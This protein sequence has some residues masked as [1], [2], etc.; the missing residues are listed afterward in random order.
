MT[1]LARV[2][3]ERL[4]KKELKLQKAEAFMVKYNE[5]ILKQQDKARIYAEKSVIRRAFSSAFG[6]FNS[7]KITIESTYEGA[8][9]PKGSAWEIPF[10]EGYVCIRGS[11]IR[12]RAWKNAPKDGVVFLPATSEDEIDVTTA[13]LLLNGES[14]IDP[15]E[16]KNYDSNRYHVD[17]LT[18]SIIV[19]K[20]GK[21]I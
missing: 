19:S 3:Q 21:R 4:T 20:T 14:V 8:H 7:L 10:I 5:D 1:D 18:P 9:K 17:T 6:F 2:A 11:R 16:L 13:G 12:I 15:K